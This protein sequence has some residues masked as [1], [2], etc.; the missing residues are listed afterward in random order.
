LVDPCLSKP[1]LNNG[2]CINRSTYNN[3]ES[4][5]CACPLAFTGDNCETSLDPCKTQVRCINGGSCLVVGLNDFKCICPNGFTGVNCEMRDSCVSSPCLNGGVCTL[6][7][8]NGYQWYFY[9]LLIEHDV[10]VFIRS[11]F[12]ENMVLNYVIHTS[13]S[14][15]RL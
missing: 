8:P 10:V 9:F 6:V 3:T 1:C 13:I 15:L 5:F 14:L 4:Y 7:L 11:D 12:F 2:I